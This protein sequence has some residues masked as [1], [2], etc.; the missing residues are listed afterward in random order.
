M[1]KEEVWKEIE[2]FEGIYEVSSF[3]R[4]KS[5]YRRG[6]WKV[7]GSEFSDGR[8]LKNGDSNRGYPMFTPSKKGVKTGLAI[9]RL[10]AKAFI[11]NE[12]NKPE[13]NHI[14]GNRKNNHV[15]NL[16]WCT[17]QENID[18]SHATGLCK[19]RD[20]DMRGEKGFHAKLKNENIHFIRSNARQNGG[21]YT[22]KQL[23][24]FFGVSRGAVKHV[25]LGNTWT[26]L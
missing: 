20:N 19:E 6:N 15:E 13:V 4:I 23:A 1:A 24:E 10:V 25:L 26:H 9:H 7:K 21:V 22:Q 2:G 8:I 5:I 17:R 18:H 16:E 3:G 11:K 14:D 12:E